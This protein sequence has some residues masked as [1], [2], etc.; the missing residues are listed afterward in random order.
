MATMTLREHLAT[1]EDQSTAVLYPEII[2]QY[3]GVTVD[4]KYDLAT[5]FREFMDL[6][7]DE[8]E[9]GD[10]TWDG[11]GQAVVGPDAGHWAGA[12]VISMVCRHNPT[13]A[14]KLRWAH[15]TGYSS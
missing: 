7:G 12:K 14:S 1:Y 11:V 9:R 3:T 4:D 13:E 5:V 2:D 6:S 15:K 8:D 10:W